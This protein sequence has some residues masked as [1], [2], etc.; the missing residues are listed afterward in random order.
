MLENKIV[1]LYIQFVYP[2]LIHI[3]MI[4]DAD[5]PPAKYSSSPDQNR[6]SMPFSN[7]SDDILLIIAEQFDEDLDVNA[8]CQTSHRLYCLLNTFIYRYNVRYYHGREM[9][10]AMEMACEEALLKFIAQGPNVQQ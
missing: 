7:L 8:P 3:E 10:R 4:Y 5:Y 6:I 2:N 9:W 1:I